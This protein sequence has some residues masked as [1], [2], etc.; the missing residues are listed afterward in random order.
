MQRP[1]AWLYKELPQNLSQH[2]QDCMDQ[3]RAEHF[4]R[5]PAGKSDDLTIYCGQ[6]H[7]STKQRNQLQRFGI[8][9][10]DQASAYPKCHSPNRIDTSNQV[11]SPLAKSG[12]FRT[13]AQRNCV[14]RGEKH[15]PFQRPGKV[16][17]HSPDSGTDRL[18]QH[19]EHHKP[20]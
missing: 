17:E 7:V 13:S 6:Q 16:Q 8:G 19:Q 2:I 11:M 10:L 3:E 9:Q 12:W 5:S 14:E 18:D 20:G 4:S 1:T 15:H